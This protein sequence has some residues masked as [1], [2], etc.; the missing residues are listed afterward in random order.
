MELRRTPSRDATPLRAALALALSLALGL[1]LAAASLAVL[2]ASRALAQ[3]ACPEPTATEAPAPTEPLVMPEGYRVAL[4]DGVWNAVNELYL[5]P[6]FNG[7][8]WQ[9]VGDEY[10]AYMLQTEDGYQVYALLEEMVALLEDPYTLFLSPTFLQEEE[11]SGQPYGGIGALLDR[12]AAAD[13]VEGLR[14]LYVFEGSPAEEAGLRSRDRVIAVDGDPCVRIEDIRGPVGT[15]VDLTVVSPGEEP[16]EVTIERQSVAPVILPDAHRIGE[17]EAVGYVRPNTLAGE[18]AI[19]GATDALTG[20]LEDGPL[21][22]L[23]VDLRTTSSGAPAV[24]ASILGQFVEGEVGTLY[25]RTGTSPLTIER[26]DLAG[27]LAGVPVVVLVDEST[28]GPAEQLAAVLQDQ[29]R[30]VVIGQQTSGRT[31]GAQSI[32]FPDGSAIQI[33]VYG[34]ELSDGRRLEETGVV[35]DIEVDDDWLAY[36]ES[37]DP[38][39]LAALDAL[40][41]GVVPGGAAAGPDVSPEP[42]RSP[43]GTPA[44]DDTIPPPDDGASPAPPATPEAPASPDAGVPDGLAPSP[45]PARTITPIATPAPP[46][47]PAPTE[48]PEPDTASE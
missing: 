38:F 35:P 5:D 20:L 2:P 27:Q 21:E 25:A 26:G 46:R 48:S 31:Q 10:S 1:A 22:G 43:D 4:F 24:I 37:D 3:E 14:I 47:T 32:D 39:L 8:D 29:G 18:G 19:A 33:V 16:R 11:S 30:G 41:S 12:S 36:P 7:V 9:A 6:D 42:G 28:E 15:P 44:P 13:D 45:A 17:D 40:A 23:I 34:L